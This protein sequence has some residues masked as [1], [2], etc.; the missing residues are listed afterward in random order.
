MMMMMEPS[1]SHQTVF[2]FIRHGTT[3]WTI[4]DL[5]KGPQDLSINEKGIACQITGLHDG[6]EMHSVLSICCL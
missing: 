2:Y 5:S 4:A 1:G 6:H 3:D